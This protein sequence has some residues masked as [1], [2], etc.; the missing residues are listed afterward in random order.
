MAITRKLNSTNKSAPPRR[1]LLVF[2]VIGL[3][4]VVVVG[5]ITL[6][7]GV[8]AA[9]WNSSGVKQIVRYV[10]LPAVS[11]NGHWRSYYD[12][13]DAVG[14]L[15]YSFSQPS[16][17][18]A[19]GLTTPPASEQVRTT[20]LDRMVK[21][22]LVQQ[23][24]KRR[25][26][27]VSVADLDAEMNKL[28][29]QS[30][31]AATVAAQIKQ[32]YNWDLD[33]FRQRVV[34]PYLRRQRLQENIGADE[35]INTAEAQRAQ[36]LVQRVQAG[37]EDFQAIARE[38]NEDVTKSTGGDLGIFGRGQR[39]AALEEAAFSLEVDQ[40]SGLVR[41]REGWHIL[42]VLEKIPADEQAG[43]GERV[44]VAH[45]FVSAKP[46]DQWLFEQAQGQRVTVFIAGF[47]WDSSNAQIV[48]KTAT[49]TNAAP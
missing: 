43:E 42:K 25:G 11:V 32:L 4:V 17:L 10:P 48:S 30:G 31:D 23:L 28:V 41:T 16:V 15:E 40:V 21:E 46:L 37:S 18:Q 3:I 7:I 2:F 9:Q 39:E 24:A 13:I 33:T 12:F 26:V 8:Y 45:L 34:E 49:T 19:S 5:V 6:T 27:A 36:Q 38:V 20:V 35:A 22:E 14:T 29:E 1:R 47:R 44:H